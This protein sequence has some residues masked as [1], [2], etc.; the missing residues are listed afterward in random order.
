MN[1]PVNVTMIEELE[2]AGLTLEDDSPEP[3]QDH[4]MRG[5]TLVVTGT[6]ETMSRSDAESRIK[7]LGAKAS[8]SVSKKTAYLVA[9]A[10]AGVGNGQNGGSA[11]VA[12]TDPS[13]MWEEITQ[14]VAF[15]M[16]RQFGGGIGANSFNPLDPL[17]R[18]RVRGGIGGFGGGG[19]LGVELGEVEL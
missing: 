14:G 16:G 6:L 19:S 10:N 2:S 9:G 18:N 13:F 15:I 7:A 5:L 8:G 1:L 4:P 11:T 12:S 3:P 17:S